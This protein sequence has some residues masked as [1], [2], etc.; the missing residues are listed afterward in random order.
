MAI[1]RGPGGSGDA[2]ADATNQ[3]LIAINAANA[4]STSASN[5]AN[6]ASN[7]A[8]SATSASASATSAAN[9][10]SSASSVLSNALDKTNN[11]SDLVDVS[12]ARTNLGLGTAATTNAS[13]YAT[14]AQGVKADT[15]LQSIA[16]GSITTSK[17]ADAN[18]TTAK[19]ANNAVTP[20]KMANGGAE[21]GMRN[22]II[23]GA[24][25]ID[26]RNAG[27]SVTAAAG[28]ATFCVDRW[29]AYTNLNSKYSMQQNAGSVTLPNGFKNYLGI[30]SLAA[31]SAGSGDY[32]LIQQ[33]IEGF[34]TADLGLGTAQASTLTLSFWVRS[35]L[36]GTFAGRL[37]N[38]ADNRSYVFTYTI[39]SANTWEYKTVTIA[40]DTLGTWV[41]AT[42]GSGLKITFD[43]GSGSGSQT[44][45]GS[46]QNGAYSTV[47]GA[48][49]VV[50]TNGATFY[51][52]GVQ[53][54]KGS[55]STAFDVRPYGAELA[56]CQRY[57]QALMGGIGIRASQ[58]IAGG[59]WASIALKV[60]MRTTP[61]GI[62]VGTWTVGNCGQPVISTSVLSPSSVMLTATATTTGDTVYY[63]D[64]NAKGI[65][66]SAEL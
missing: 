28:V 58:V 22:R 40:G 7:A 19:L 43:L 30:T 59:L 48:T 50:G 37:M 62:V 55:T 8:S 16:D 52:T 34:N 10:A 35:S 2:T 42:N 26:Q 36:T 11:L 38:G 29:G 13:A 27:A 1:Y 46:W 66:L 44:T 32:F 33:N 17:I 31:T 64:T 25:M 54:E 60:E 18:V 41:G 23:N 56:L 5:A 21:F 49:S 3:A 20:A 65:T 4:A 15:A 51:I 45:A 14:A 24:M 47:A 53:L 9:S 57:Y 61:T 63:T 12:V 6:S 39:S